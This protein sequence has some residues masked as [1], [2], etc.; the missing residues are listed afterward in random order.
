MI[1][2]GIRT[3]QA[4]ESAVRQRVNR[5][6]DAKEHNPS[7]TDEYIVA[8][9]VELCELLRLFDV[10]RCQLAA[11]RQKTWSGVISSRTTVKYMLF[12]LMRCPIQRLLPPPRCCPW[13][14]IPPC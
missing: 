8:L 11:A 4:I 1:T 7:P 12:A 6:S 10:H 3:V 5:A 2:D 13:A 9:R 14:A